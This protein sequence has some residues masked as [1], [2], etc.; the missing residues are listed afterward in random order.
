A[1]ARAIGGEYQHA[2]GA[3]GEHQAIGRYG[4]SVRQTLAAVAGQVGC[5]GK[6]ALVDDVALRIEGVGHPD[7]PLLVGVGHVQGVA[8]GR[9]RDAVG[10]AQRIVQQVH[11][12]VCVDAVNAVDR[13]LLEIG[14]A[15]V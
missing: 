4:Q 15:H 14:R 13:L 2:A 5:I 6:L 3:G 12:A 9:E 7:R 8:V 1:Q 11:A 10:T